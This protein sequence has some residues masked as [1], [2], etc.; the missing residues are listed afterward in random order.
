MY[1]SV[2]T[3]QQHLGDAGRGTEV[4]VDLERRVGVEEVRECAAV[5][6]LAGSV[7]RWQ[8][9]QHVLEDG[10]GMAAVEHTCPEAYLPSEAPSCGLVTTVGQGLF[11]CGE[12]F[13]VVVGTDLVGG[14]ESV[15][16]GDMP[17]LPL[18]AIGIDEPLQELLAAANLHGWQQSQCLLESL[19]VLSVLAED[20]RRIQCVR[21]SIEDDLVVHGAPSGDGC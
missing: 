21:Q 7:L 9:S 14:K 5:W 19:L 13:V 2:V 12:E 17:V 10:Q 20:T 18:T 3:L 8:Q 6:I 1:G 4:S 15:E 16:M 11:G